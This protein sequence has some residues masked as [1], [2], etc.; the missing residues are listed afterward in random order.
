[1]A[2]CLFTGL[3]P[4]FGAVSLLKNN[5]A[6]YNLFCFFLLCTGKIQGEPEIGGLSGRVVFLL[7]FSRICLYCRF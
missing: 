2:F 1:M 7:L 5:S 4:V 6:K 3:W